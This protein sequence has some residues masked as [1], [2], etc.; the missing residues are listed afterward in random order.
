MH[1]NTRR[2]HEDEAFVLVA[3]PLRILY[4]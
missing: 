4:Q 1:R 2:I 3:V